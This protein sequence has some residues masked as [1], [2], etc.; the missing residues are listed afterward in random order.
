LDFDVAVPSNGPMIG[1]AE[2]E[3]FKNKI[4]TMVSQATKL[5]KMGV[6]EDQFMAELKT[7]DLGSRLNFN[8]GQLHSLYAELSQKR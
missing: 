7:D 1:R 4:D 5:V 3:A 8:G 2:L 6:S